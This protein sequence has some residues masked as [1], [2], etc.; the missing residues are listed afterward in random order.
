[1]KYISE[2]T[3]KARCGARTRDHMLKRHTLYQTELTGQFDT[4]SGSS[5]V[6]NLKV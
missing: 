6:I 5:S 4:I 1:M 3:K 2:L